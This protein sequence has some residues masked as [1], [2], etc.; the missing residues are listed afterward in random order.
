LE[1]EMVKSPP[2]SILITSLYQKKFNYIAKDTNILHLKSSSCGRPSYF[3]TAT[4]AKIFLTSN[5]NYLLFCN[6]THKTETGIAIGWELLVAN[7]LD[8]S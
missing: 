1:L 4:L 2:L 6:P 8:Q 3:P 7:H 5:F